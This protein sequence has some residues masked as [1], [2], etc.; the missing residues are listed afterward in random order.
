MTM[1]TIIISASVLGLTA[2]LGACDKDVPAPKDAQPVA[3]HNAAADSAKPVDT[4][5]D[6]GAKD[7][8]GAK[9]AFDPRVVK[10]AT[11]AEQIEA[12]PTH[13]DEVLAKAGMDRAALDA[14]LYEVSEPDLAEQYRLARA[15]GKH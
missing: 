3:E 15:Q 5:P 6:K 4:A 14:L 13:A 8:A 10:A 1:R 2:A 9:E 11:L 12:D 7:N